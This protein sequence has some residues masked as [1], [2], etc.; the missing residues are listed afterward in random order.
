MITPNLQSDLFLLPLAIAS[1]ALPDLKLSGSV[2]RVQSQIHPGATLCSLR[3]L[4]DVAGPQT[5]LHTQAYT[6]PPTRPTA[7]S[8]LCGGVLNTASALEPA[9]T[10][11][12]R[13]RRGPR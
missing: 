11:A 3:C 13:T 5:K 1:G 10:H 6:L 2:W 4:Y 8:T 9:H 12:P 7:R